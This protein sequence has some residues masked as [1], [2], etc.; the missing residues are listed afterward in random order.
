[1]LVPESDEEDK[2]LVFKDLEGK[3]WQICRVEE[4]IEKDFNKIIDESDMGGDKA[5]AAAMDKEGGTEIRKPNEREAQVANTIA[6][7]LERF[8]EP[9]TYRL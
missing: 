4:N 3:L 6:E 8:D 1:M 2:L 5:V 7:H 9:Q